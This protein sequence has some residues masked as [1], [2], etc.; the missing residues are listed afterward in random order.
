MSNREMDTN[1]RLEYLLATQTKEELLDICRSLKIKGISNLRKSKLIGM[2]TKRI[3]ETVATKMQYWDQPIYD[4]V[5]QIITSP[6]T[7]Y[8]ELDDN[9]FSEDYLL[10]EAIA[11]NGKDAYGEYLV[12]PDEIR[13]L[14]AS[15]D[16]ELYRNTI[17]RNTQIA[18]LSKGLLHYYGYLAWDELRGFLDKLLPSP[19]EAHTI[20]SVLWEVGLYNWDII[21]ERGYFCDGRLTDLD[22]LFGELN[23]R[24][25]LE[26]KPLTY[27]EVWEAGDPKYFHGQAREVH[28]LVKFLA[29]REMDEFAP[30]FI[31]LLYGL[32]QTEL[33]PPEVVFAL[34]EHLDTAS[35]AD[36]TEL[37]L[38][39]FDFYHQV[40]HWVLKG[41]S[42]EEIMNHAPKQLFPI[43]PQSEGQMGV[44]YDFATRKRMELDAPCP[45]GSDL[46][47]K[48]C[49][50][51][52][53]VPS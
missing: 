20:W 24:K 44:V 31:D 34:V 23:T 27:K 12:I 11:F 14:V 48:N 32:V 1:L 49:C 46:Q 50:G 7:Y 51:K 52:K 39:V 22:Y 38:L 33:S 17:A 36:I 35:E 19:L 4:L 42:P 2:L 13:R 5:Q 9:V 15:L 8:L 25:S 29:E 43:A 53:V 30:Y 21:S 10:G 41:H 3:P 37:A 28:D 18:R 47:F 16:G 26:Y 6:Q 45:C 40:P